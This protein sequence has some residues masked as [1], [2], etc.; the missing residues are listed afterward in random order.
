MNKKTL[1]YILL[2]VL[3]AVLLF[4]VF[5]LA[6]ISPPEATPT[7][8]PASL[9]AATNTPEPASPPTASIQ[10][11]TWQWISLTNQTTG[12]T[13]P[14][15]APENYT[16]TFNADGTLTGKADCN[17][18]A[19]SYSQENGF[20]I[21]LD[22]STM[23]FCSDVSLDQ[24]YLALLGSVAAGGPDGAGRLC[25]GNG[26]RRAAPAL[27]EWRHCPAVTL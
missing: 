27:P 12:A 1:F 23:A 2:A 26:R 15:P 18:F 4:T 3:A 7:P 9:P 5:G 20:S 16:I 10:G 6:V 22:A 11:I 21:Q 19:G 13:T 24:Q 14:V 25:F 17:N 8:E